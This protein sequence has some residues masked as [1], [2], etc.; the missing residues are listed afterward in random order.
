MDGSLE[1]SKQAVEAVRKISGRT[2]SY[3]WLLRAQRSNNGW[4]EYMTRSEDVKERWDSVKRDFPD[5][6][7][8]FLRESI[9]PPRGFSPYFGLTIARVV[10]YLV[11]FNRWDDAYAVTSQ[12]VDSIRDLVSGQE[13]PIPQWTGSAE[14]L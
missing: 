3:D 8:H 12:L 5:R 2:R 11:H 7:H 4:H 9:R 10:E 13:L 1:V 14:G 6:W